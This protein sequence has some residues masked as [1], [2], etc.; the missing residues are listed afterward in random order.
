V[1]SV[2]L[3]MP[4]VQ[5]ISVLYK[6]ETGRNRVGNKQE[7]GRERTREAESGSRR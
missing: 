6:T 1:N 4:V 2:Y 3:M 5:I 7:R